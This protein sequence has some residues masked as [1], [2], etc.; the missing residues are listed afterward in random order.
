MPN[1]RGLLLWMTWLSGNPNCQVRCSIRGLGQGPESGFG[2]ACFTLHISKAC[3]S[4]KSEIYYSSQF[5]NYIILLYRP[6]YAR[7]ESAQGNNVEDMLLTAA[8]RITRTVDDLLSERKSRCAPLHVY[9]HLIP[10]ILLSC[11]VKFRIDSSVSI[12]S[13]MKL[14]S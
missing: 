5:S 7:S 3:I 12:S 13:R 8:N 14:A 4:P 9:V 6:G 1:L 11:R 10:S 2:Q